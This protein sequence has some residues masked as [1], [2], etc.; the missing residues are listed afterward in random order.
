MNKENDK[1]W[2]RIKYLGGGGLLLLTFSGVT[3]LTFNWWHW[4]IALLFI[5]LMA[6][7]IFIYFRTID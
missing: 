2:K 5:I 4:V 1:A 3:V 7:W 6:I